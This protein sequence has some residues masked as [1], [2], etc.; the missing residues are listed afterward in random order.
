MAVRHDG[1]ARRREPRLVV[2]QEGHAFGVRLLAA[3][4]VPPPCRAAEAR[5][6]AFRPLPPPVEV[7]PLSEM[8]STAAP[9]PSGGV[10]DSGAEAAEQPAPLRYA[11]EPT[12]RARPAPNTAPPPP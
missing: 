11:K 12:P 8:R 1:A 2:V 3:G 9:A 6:V 7:A 4:A 5:F 10:D